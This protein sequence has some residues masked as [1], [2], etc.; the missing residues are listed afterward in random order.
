MR[1]S[2]QT[3]FEPGIEKKAVK[4]EKMALIALT[5]VFPFSTPLGAEPGPVGQWL[6]N[7]PVTLWDRGMDAINEAVGQAVEDTLY[8]TDSAVYDWDNNEITIAINATVEKD[9]VSHDIC[10]TL[11]RAAI[12]AIVGI[13]WD[14]DKRDRPK[15]E[16]S[17]G[18]GGEGQPPV[19]QWL[20]EQRIPQQVSDWF[21]HSG[22]FRSDRD[23]N[24]GEK[25]ARIIFVQFNLSAQQENNGIS[26]RDRITSL[27]APSKPMER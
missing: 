26:C 13:G 25:V 16:F 2:R 20:V 4:F 21:S 6:M 24:L 12:G 17:S 22:Y 8:E 18:Y 23:R 11:R 15:S 1:R 7:E 27:E 3:F 5:W 19:S 9:F 10:N 14:W